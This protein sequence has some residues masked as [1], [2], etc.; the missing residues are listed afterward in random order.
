MPDINQRKN[1]YKALI[2]IFPALYLILGFYFRQVF[3]DLSLRSF[4]PDYIHF[5][6][7]LCVSTGKFSQANIDQPASAMHL[8]LALV[9]KVVYFFRSHNTPYFQDVIRNSDLYLSIGNLVITAII[10]A[11][12]LWTG[13]AV[14]KI[15]KSVLY[16]VMIQTSPFLMNIWYDLIGRIYVELLFVIPIFILQVL[17]F[18]EIFGKWKNKNHRNLYYGFAVGLGLS[19]KMTFLPFLVLPL[20]VIKDFRDK[21]KYLFYAAISF[22]VLS[23]PVIFQFKRFLNWNIGLILHSGTYQ[24]GAKTMINPGLFLKNLKALIVSQHDFFYVLMVLAILFVVLLFKRSWKSIFKRI[25]L[26]LMVALSGIIFITCKHFELRYFIPALLFFPFLLILVKEQISHFINSKDLNLLMSFLLLL[27]IGYKIQQQVPYIRIVSESVSGQMEARIETRNVI[28]T[29]K[30]DSYKI[31][32]SQDY[33]SPFQEYSI[34]YGFC[35]AGQNWP[36]Y[37]EKLDKIYPDTYQYFTWSNTLKYWGKDFD[38]DSV[39]ASGKPV[40]LYLEK[41]NT[42]LYKKML[43]KLFKSDSALTVTKKLIFENPVNGEAMLQLFL[44]KVKKKN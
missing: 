26:G 36:G 27:I 6:S 14:E 8:L 10:A 23:L 17:I 2:Y 40:Y 15:S 33:G 18:R 5:I 9:F 7:G 1:Y 34:M 16:A 38:P 19:L 35:M 28:K 24:E 43:D 12:M 42:E 11:A 3:G 29:L 44:T 4:D 22:S 31:I 37:K 20:F 13:K 25:D 30:K 21:I 41:N 32:V 39:L